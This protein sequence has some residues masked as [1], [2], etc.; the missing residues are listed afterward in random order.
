MNIAR[1]WKPIELRSRRYFIEKIEWTKRKKCFKWR[2]ES[3]RDG[4]WKTRD[5][6]TTSMGVSV[7]YG[8]ADR[9]KSRIY[10]I[11]YPRKQSIVTP[12]EWGNKRKKK[13]T[14]TFDKKPEWPDRN[15]RALKPKSLRVF[16]SSTSFNE[17]KSTFYRYLALALS[18]QT[19]L[20]K[21]D[22]FKNEK[23]TRE[24]ISQQFKKLIFWRIN[25]QKNC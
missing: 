18:S 14:H 3:S 1:V 9:E 21:I 10:G 13:H 23:Y 11:P 17:N 6:N 7:R 24:N 15:S 22:G 16:Y 12:N 2:R 5:R 8:K 25:N 4:R 20:P 19:T